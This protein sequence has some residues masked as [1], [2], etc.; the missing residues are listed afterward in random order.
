MKTIGRITTVMLSTAGS[1]PAAG[2]SEETELSIM[3]MLFLAFG[4]L[5]V[6]MQAIS[7]VWVLRSLCREIMNRPAKKRLPA[8]KQVRF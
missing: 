3:A 1:A 4:A 8:G 5:I 6:V 2:G 7:R